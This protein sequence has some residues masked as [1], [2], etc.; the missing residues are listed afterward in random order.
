MANL[1]EAFDIQTTDREIAL[2]IGLPYLFSKEGDS[3][4][5]GAMLQEPWYFNAYL[6]PLGLNF[7]QVPTTRREALGLLGSKAP[8]MVGLAGDYGRHAMICLGREGERYRFLNPHREGDG[9][10]D[11]LELSR[12][13]VYDRLS[14]CAM[15]GFL[16]RC[17]PRAWD[18]KAEIMDAVNTLGEYVAAVEAFCAEPRTREEVR[19]H[20]DPLFRAFAL[21]LPAMM[22]LAG[23]W[24]LVELLRRFQA[25]AIAMAHAGDCTP[26]AFIDLENFHRAAHRYEALLKE[27][28]K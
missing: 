22:E 14:D 3:F 17:E 23:E 8:C 13:A 27:K 19:E 25:Q 2:E 18:H 15:V 11:Y 12:E 24:E 1:L 16:E 26:S 20:M 10:K 28:M 21:D 5:A 9:Q 4:C 6:N 7:S